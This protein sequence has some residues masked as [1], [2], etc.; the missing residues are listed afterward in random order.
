SPV[1]APIGAVA[2]ALAAKIMYGQ[3]F[4]AWSQTIGAISVS[5][6]YGAAAH[7]LRR[8][9]KIDFGLGRQRDVVRY[10]SVTTLAALASTG[11]GVLCVLALVRSRC[12]SCDRTG[13]AGNCIRHWRGRI[14]VHRFH[15]G[16]LG[17]LPARHAQS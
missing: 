13:N 4:S 9:M 15:P 10:L 5:A 1:F 8:H 6:I 12:S 2:I 11:V 14:A 16:H 3:P 7:V 17:C